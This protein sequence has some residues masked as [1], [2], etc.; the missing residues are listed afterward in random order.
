MSKLYIF[1]MGNVV[2]TNK[3]QELERIMNDNKCQLDMTNLHKTKLHRKFHTGKIS[4]NEYW[5]GFNSIYNTSIL[6]PQWGKYFE[7]QMN[8]ETLDLIKELKQNNRVVCGTNVNE[9][10]WQ[11]HQERDDYRIFPKVYP[12]HHMGVA[13]P[14]PEFWNII[15]EKEGYKPEDTFFIDDY[16]ENVKGAASLGIHSF[17]FTDVKHL[18]EEL[19]ISVKVP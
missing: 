17:L 9:S 15:L 2:F 1:D 6:A 12:S 19:K 18:R 11:I 8:Q 5:K 7:P 16:I 3:F 10:H 14:D 4:E 13:K